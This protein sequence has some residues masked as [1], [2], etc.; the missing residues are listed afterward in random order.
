[1]KLQQLLSFTRKAVDTYQTVSYTHLD[2]YKRQPYTYV[3]SGQPAYKLVHNHQWQIVIPLT[4]E[5]AS[6]L[7]EMCIRDRYQHREIHWRELI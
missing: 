4:T 3:E 7:E 6:E 5:Q 1:M 2:V